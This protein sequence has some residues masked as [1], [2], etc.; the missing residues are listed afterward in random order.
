MVP[1]IR[2]TSY[3]P[4]QRFPYGNRWKPT[5]SHTNLWKQKWPTI[6]TSHNRGFPHTNTME[7]STG[8]RLH[9]ETYGNLSYIRKGRRGQGSLKI[10]T[11]E[12]HGP[13]PRYRQTLRT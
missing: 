11:D 3:E 2:L 5:I 10:T 12:V 6:T 13:K 9:M 1:I 4:Q 7:I 8:Q